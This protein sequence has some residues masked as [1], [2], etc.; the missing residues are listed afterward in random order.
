MAHN[1]Q[2]KIDTVHVT[3]QALS[4]TEERLTAKEVA[5]AIVTQVDK[6]V[7]KEEPSKVDN[8]QNT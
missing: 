5:D 8:T 1:T 7:P 6:V 2:V 4:D 3:A